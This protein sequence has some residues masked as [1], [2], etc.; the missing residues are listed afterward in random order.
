[1]AGAHARLGQAERVAE[2]D[3]G[4]S[5]NSWAGAAA[6]AAQLRRLAEASLRDDVRQDGSVRVQTLDR[7]SLG[8]SVGCDG[9]VGMPPTRRPGVSDTAADNLEDSSTEVIRRQQRSGNGASA[10]GDS[11]SGPAGGSAVVFR[12]C[13]CCGVYM[14]GSLWRRKIKTGGRHRGVNLYCG[15]QWDVLEAAAPAVH[16]D[17]VAKHR[18]QEP[19][20]GCGARYFLYK[21]GPAAVVEVLV[22]GVYRIE[23]AD[24]MLADD[25]SILTFPLAQEYVVPGL[26]FAGQ[27][28]FL[29]H[30]HGNTR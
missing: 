8:S 10:A 22:D 26:P 4:P 24:P 11:A 23:P 29:A 13:P 3:S 16:A 21:R 2:Q 14:H 28:E 12:R 18:N 7:E 6:V 1:M 27:V 9:G 30:G 5:K 25:S 17:V 20:I 15:V 19:W